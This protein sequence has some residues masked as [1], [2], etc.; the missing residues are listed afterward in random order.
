MTPADHRASATAPASTPPHPIIHWVLLGVSI[1][2]TAA[3]CLWASERREV[4]VLIYGRVSYWLILALICVWIWQASRFLVA[5]RFSPASFVR[6]HWVPLAAALGMTFMAVNSVPS[7]FRVL[8][9][10]TNLL[11]VSQSMLYHKTAFNSTQQKRYYGA[12]QPISFELEKRPLV[13]PFIVHLVH[14]VRGYSPQNAFVLNAGV[15]F[16]LLALVGIA[17]KTNV[18]SVAAVATIVLVGAH[19][20]VVTTARSG[21]FDLL[22]T[23]LTALSFVLAYLHMREPSPRRLAVLFATLLVFAQV[24]YESAIYIVVIGLCLIILGYA[25]WRYISAHI[26]LYVAAPLLMLPLFVQRILMPHPYENGPGVAA[27]G[28]EHFRKFIRRFG[29]A[30]LDLGFLQPHV[31]ILYWLAVPALILLAFRFVRRRRA[32]ESRTECHWVFMASLALL[33]S[34]GL[35]FSYYFGD[36]THP[37]SARFYLNLSV[38]VA[39]LPVGLHQ[40]L[41]ALIT[42]ARLLVG[43][44]ALAVLYHPVSVAGRFTATQTLWRESELEWQFL[45]RRGDPNVLVVTSRPGQ[46][47]ALNYGAVNFGYAQ[48]NAA[49]LLLELRR[50]LY[51]DILV[52]QRISYD[53]EN[54]VPDDQLGSMFRLQSVVERQSSATEFVRI[55]RVVL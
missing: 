54:P 28:Y 6:R 14:L 32:P 44:I 49:S 24:R 27:F 5:Q 53:T 10:E 22:A 7:Q 13:F 23:F 12:M 16:A 15:Y 11:G 36:F 38:L 26:G 48:G 37:A 8:S 39:L 50:R 45:E 42:P 35:V 47:T 2:I 30:Q 40:C 29:E 17:V 51:S 4:G 43:A 33:V 41:P 31:P 55:S 19:P 9:D 1:A 3:I 21:G 25:P 20:L 34:H 46:F 52:F 18:G